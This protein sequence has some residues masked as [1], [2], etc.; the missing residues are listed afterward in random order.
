MC[1]GWRRFGWGR[2]SD[3]VRGWCST[4]L[5]ELGR[6]GK[7]CDSEFFTDVPL[8]SWA[9]ATTDQIVGVL[10]VTG[11]HGGRPFADAE[12]EFLRLL[13]SMAA[14][15]IDNFVSRQARNEAHDSVV[16]ALATLA[17]HRDTETGKHLERV[18][19]YALYLSDELR[20]EEPFRTQIDDDFVRELRR[21]M[22]LH[23]IGKVAV[24]DHILL[25]P[26]KLTPIEIT[27]M[28][29][30]AEAGAETLRS[31][32][33]RAPG[34]WFLKMAEQIAL[35]H[36]EWYDGSGYPR[37]LKESAIPLSARIAALADVYDALTSKR[38]YKDAMPHAQA[39]HIIREGRGSQF[40]PAIVDAFFRREAEFSM[41]AE[42]ADD[43]AAI[44]LSAPPNQAII[45][46]VVVGAEMP[47]APVGFG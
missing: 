40:D 33:K 14:S 22:P 2:I 18:T 5:E 28:R 27:I 36:H 3:P 45:N 47:A 26:G 10:N 21:A 34:A 31:V 35:C 16:T 38:P 20:K 7:L 42:G 15:A 4:V 6:Q 29:Q 39:A 37:G 24:P 44:E 46:A 23:D 41:A 11:R 32:M 30:H 43:T 1:P 17:E 12:L 8:I 9:L 19:A 25:K 13:S